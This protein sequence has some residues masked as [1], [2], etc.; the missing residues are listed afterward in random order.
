MCSIPTKRGEFDKEEERG[1]MNE[2]TQSKG[3]EIQSNPVPT[4]AF[5]GV[6]FKTR[7]LLE[8]WAANVLKRDLDKKAD[9]LKLH[10][11]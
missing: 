9:S 5:Q 7:G 8:S 3:E 11:G 6:F 10:E 1:S 4:R 2:E